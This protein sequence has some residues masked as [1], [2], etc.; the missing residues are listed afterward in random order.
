[1]ILVTEQKQV[2]DIENRFVTKGEGQEGG[3]DW[4]FQISRG[5]I[6]I[7]RLNNKILLNSTENYS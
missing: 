3:K 5:K 4:D 6:Y 1:M 7:E 2:T